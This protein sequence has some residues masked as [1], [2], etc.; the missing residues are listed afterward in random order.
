M[1][2]STT[3]VT[4]S[5]TSRGFRSGGVGGGRRGQALIYIVKPLLKGLP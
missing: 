1:L 2:A 4:A 5:G 3:S